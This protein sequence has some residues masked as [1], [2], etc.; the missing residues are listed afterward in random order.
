MGLRGTMRRWRF[1]SGE[2]MVLNFPRGVQLSNEQSLK[3][4]G[5]LSGAGQQNFWQC[6]ES[7]ISASLHLVATSHMGLLCGWDVVNV[8]NTDCGGLSRN[9]P[10]RFIV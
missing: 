3:T 8:M 6:G 1:S 9:D 4:V 5:H 7:S 2:V 10:R